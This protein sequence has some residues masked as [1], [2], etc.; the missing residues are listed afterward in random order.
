MAPD[1]SRGGGGNLRQMNAKDMPLEWVVFFSAFLVCQCFL[2]LAVLG[3]PVGP[4][5]T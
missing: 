3:M 2:I 4:N 5:F 1:Y